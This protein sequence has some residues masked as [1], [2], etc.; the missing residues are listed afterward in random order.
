MV[1]SVPR[2]SAVDTA[3]ALND[4]LLPLVARGM[5]VRRPP[6]VAVLDRLDADRRAIRRMQRLRDRYGPGPLLLAMPGR[7]VVLVLSPGD[8]REVLDRTPEPFAT[9]NREKRA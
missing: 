9:A 1:E 8:V 2:A 3:R 7:D 6:V 5:I 4:V